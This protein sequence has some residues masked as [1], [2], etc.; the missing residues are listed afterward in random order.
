[1]FITDRLQNI[2]RQRYDEYINS[3]ANEK[4]CEIFN[5][6]NIVKQKYYD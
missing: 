1:M 3:L 6:C 4:K 2:F 5:K